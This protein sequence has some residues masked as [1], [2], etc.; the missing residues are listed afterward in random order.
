MGD[1]D[2][3]RSHNGL[4][5][6]HHKKKP[7]FE[8]PKNHNHSQPFSIP[9]LQPLATPGKPLP[10]PPEIDQKYADRV[11]TH[12]ST[13]STHLDK[14][15]SVSYDDLEFIGDAYIEV[16]ASN[17]IYQRFSSLP[18]GRKSQ[19]RESLVKN[20]TLARFTEGY[21]WDKKIKGG[22]QIQHESPHA[23]IKIK[24]DV[25]EAFVAAAVLSHPSYTEGLVAI[26]PW[27]HALWRPI[28]DA[29]A[30]SNPS[31]PSSQHKVE[32][33]KKISG[34]GIKIDYIDEK[35]PVIHK[36]KGVETY[37]VGAYLTGWGWDNRFLGSGK[38]L[39]RK[40]A[41]QEAAAAALAN[42]SLIDEIVEKKNAMTVQVKEE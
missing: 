8:N 22:K 6:Q 25:F 14:Q 28:T 16:I 10:T 35:Q 4:V 7:R 11:F 24:G 12:I 32:L 1:Y 17:L 42:T 40:A 39:S 18:T 26:E 13:V 33:A 23:W 3:K 38:G 15:S 30:A 19:L 20:E 9:A 2:R 31:P 37:Y 27:L 34:K 29:L 5:D 21:G 36:G 41:G